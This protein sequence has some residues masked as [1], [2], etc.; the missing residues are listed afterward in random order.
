MKYAPLPTQRELDQVT[1][2]MG[3]RTLSFVRRILGGLGCTMDV[4]D[5]D[6]LPVVLRRYGPWATDEPT[7]R[8]VREARA[9]TLANDAGKD[10]KAGSL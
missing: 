1:D 10:Q 2:A 6:G 7:N 4:L 3:L 9:L 8:A 5:A